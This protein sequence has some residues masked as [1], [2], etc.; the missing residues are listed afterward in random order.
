MSNNI[1]IQTHKLYLMFANGLNYEILMLKLC[2]GIFY[3]R[4]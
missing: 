3:R 1:R 4:K 2:W